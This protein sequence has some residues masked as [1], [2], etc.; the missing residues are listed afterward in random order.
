MAPLHWYAPALR[1][2]TL[3]S[4]DHC[5]RFLSIGRE[6][7]MPETVVETGNPCL[8]VQKSAIQRDISQ[9]GFDKTPSPWLAYS[10]WTPA[11]I[12]SSFATFLG[13]MPDCSGE[14]PLPLA[15]SHGYWRSGRGQSLCLLLNPGD[16]TLPGKESMVA[17]TS[18]PA[19][20]S[21][22]AG[23]ASRYR[24]TAPRNPQPC[25]TNP[26]FLEVRPLRVLLVYSEFPAEVGVRSNQTTQRKSHL[27][28]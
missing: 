16:R 8:L 5:C 4:S 2:A 21:T 3:G 17:S 27:C 1:S 6:I 22:S 14:L 28:C 11:K 10:G 23:D 12:R 9:T 25:Q 15:Q 13:T 18:T 7:P 19:V 20:P 26:L 24:Q